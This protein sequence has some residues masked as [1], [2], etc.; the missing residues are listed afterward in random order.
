MKSYFDVFGSITFCPTVHLILAIWITIY[1]YSIACIISI[2]YFSCLCV[3]I[4]LTYWLITCSVILGI[5]ERMCLFV[6][7]GTG[8]NWAVLLVA[9]LFFYS[10]SIRLYR[11][12]YDYTEYIV[13]TRSLTWFSSNSFVKTCPIF[14]TMNLWC[15]RVC[16]QSCMRMKI[17]VH[18]IMGQI[19][20]NAF[21]N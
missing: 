6:W 7:Y 3:Y 5:H 12:I 8:Y 21:N 18:W 11:N 20:E 9:C 1:L 15:V 2:A 17:N 10:F 16:E 14:R 4:F 19:D 13:F